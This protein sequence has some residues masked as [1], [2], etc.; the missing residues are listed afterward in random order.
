[1]QKSEWLDQVSEVALEPARPICDPHHH[2]WDHPESRYLLDEI[3]Q[4]TDSGHNIVSTVFVECDSMYRQEGSVALAPVGETE[5]VQGI[6]AMSASGQYGDTRVAAGI[7]GFA[8]L[9]LGSDVRSVLEAHQI[10]GANRFSGIR[11]ATGWHLSEE[12]RNSHT[13]PPESLMLDGKFREGFSVLDDM[14]LTFDSWF[15]HH[16][17][18]EF[19]DL[20]KAFPGVTIVLD[21]FGGPLGIGPYDVDET[22]PVWKDQIAELKDCSNV[23]FKLGGINMKINGFGWHRKDCPPTSDELVDRTGRYYDF[24]IESFGADR[25][26]FESNF[27]VDRESCSYGVLWNAFKKIAAKRSEGEKAAL[28]HDT[29]VRVYGIAGSTT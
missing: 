14:G 10:A 23:H 8:D 1:M 20:A 22:F 13:N 28:F 4:D 19:I 24:C 7:V 5:F 26:M 15:Y 27:P 25:C 21:H 6:A 2:L 17:L 3:M 12:I 9:S 16:Q 18:A 11:H 29:A